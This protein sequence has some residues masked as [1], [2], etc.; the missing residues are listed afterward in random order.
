[1]R[2]IAERG[3]KA[4]QA[5]APADFIAAAGEYGEALDALGSSLGVE[6]VTA[7]HRQIAAIAQRFG[8]AYKVS[9][10][11]GGDVGIGLAADP[12]VLDA[13]ALAL[14]GDFEVLRIGIDPR[15][16][17]VEVRQQ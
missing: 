16:L 12:A 7:E 8:V 2:R 10:A 17:A 14:A 6:I 11:G 5:N 15:G 13:F 4:A 9:G 3:V 1:M